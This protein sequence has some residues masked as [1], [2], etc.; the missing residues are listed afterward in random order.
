MND[1]TEILPA[2]RPAHVA[3]YMRRASP[4]A[5]PTKIERK[6]TPTRK[7]RAA[8]AAMVW[9]G[10]KR[11]EA[12]ELAGM[13]DHGLRAALRRPHVKAAYLGELAVLRDSER[14]RNVH[15][16]VDVRDGSNAMARVSAAR[17]LEEMADP[18]GR[19]I[20]NVN[21]AVRAGFILDLREDV[22]Q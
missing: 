4:D 5:P 15:A 17:S 1:Q 20:V 21:V 18:G 14:A 11:S 3:T 8:I 6:L 22:D 9:S 2:K 13:S 16:L 12:A 19:S 10:S 7:V